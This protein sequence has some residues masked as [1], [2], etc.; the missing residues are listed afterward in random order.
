MDKIDGQIIMLI[1]FVVVSGIKWFVEQIKQRNIHPHETS[2]SLED[3]Y[4]EFREEI[5]ERQTEVRH[6]QDTHPS[7]HEEFAQPHSTP[8]PLPPTRAYQPAY[9]PPP[10][11][12]TPPTFQVHQPKLTAQEKA[13]LA[14]LQMR[15]NVKT[16]RHFPNNKHNSLR[17]LLASPQSARQAIILHEVLG[18][19]KGLYSKN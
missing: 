17:K 5:R 8:P 9:Q 1:L 16:K 11:P 12:S 7:H 19:P 4:E 13:A 15:S 6:P 2:E 3:I 14:N 10:T 18:T